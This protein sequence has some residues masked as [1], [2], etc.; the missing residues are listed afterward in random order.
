M[1]P[2]TLPKVNLSAVDKIAHVI[3]YFILI[4]LWQGYFYIRDD[5]KLKANS[6][7]VIFFIVLG[8]GIII[9]IVQELF[10]ANRHAD[11]FDII[12]NTVGAILGIVFFRMAKH[13][14]KH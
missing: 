14:F 4:G 5:F 9:E 13:N 6:I 3:I 8:Y 11:V 1:A 7:A 12:A 2:T 10:T